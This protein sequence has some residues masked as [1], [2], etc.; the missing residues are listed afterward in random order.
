MNRVCVHVPAHFLSETFV[1]CLE[2]VLPFDEILIQDNSSND[3]LKNYLE[4]RNEKNIR[5]F[6]SNI[7]DIR[8]RL[9]FFRFYSE[10]EYILWVHT[11]EVYNSLLIS[12]IYEKIN[13]N[14]KING[15]NIYHRSFDFGEDIGI[16]PTP[17]LRLFKKD[18]FS[19]SWNNVHDMPTVTG[20]IG[21]LKNT[22]V[23]TANYIFATSA[24]KNIKYEFINIHGISS[25]RLDELTFDNKSKLA[26]L[27][28][29]FILF[30][31]IN[32]QFLKVFLSFH[33]LTYA[34]T[35]MWANQILALLCDVIMPTDELRMRNSKIP[36][37][38]RGYI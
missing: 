30:L 12:E 17:Q 23:H 7:L 8:E 27:K 24:I 34:R 32:Y 3:D 31:K 18:S 14:E 10:C 28:V 26:L 6:K 37:D 1:K 36:K 25:K 4:Q 5:Y 21:T 20:M 2:S 38:T 29:F 15:F 35:C 19:I 33:A 22:Y 11:D 13:S 16:W 9:W